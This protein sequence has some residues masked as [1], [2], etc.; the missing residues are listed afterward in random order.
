MDA[1]FDV[2]DTSYGCLDCHSKFRLGEMIA[3]NHGILCPTCRGQHYHP[4]D[5]TVHKMT[6]YFGSI[7]TKN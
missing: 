1:E 3:S 2:L 5:G 7:G 6:E 4:I